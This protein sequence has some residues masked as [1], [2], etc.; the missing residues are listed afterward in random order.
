VQET[1]YHSL[2]K[3]RIL[4][5][6]ILV[7]D[8]RQKSKIYSWNATTFAEEHQLLLNFKEVLES[9]HESTTLF[10]TYDGKDYD[11][12]MLLSRALVHDIDVSKLFSCEHVDV[13]TF[14]KSYTLFSSKNIFDVASFL[15]CKSYADE[16]EN[17]KEI[18]ASALLASDGVEA[19]EEYNLTIL[20]ILAEIFEKT[21][22]YMLS[23]YEWGT[24]QKRVSSED[25]IFA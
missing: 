23:D 9:M 25:T 6:G 8:E 22:K 3:N 10:I 18:S 13:F 24:S 19:V 4:S 17:L 21:K 20:T 2:E 7:V 5:L 16:R 15:N 14:L 11:Y 1:G 12:K